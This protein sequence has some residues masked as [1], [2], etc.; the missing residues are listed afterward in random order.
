VVD[1]VSEDIL[2]VDGVVPG[3]SSHAVG[4]LPIG[5]AVATDGREA[6]VASAGEESVT[7]L[8]AETLRTAGLGAPR[9]FALSDTPSAMRLVR[10]DGADR[11]VVA[12]PDEGTIVALDPAGAY[13]ADAGPDA[14]PR[15]GEEV[16]VVPLGAPVGGGDAGP[17]AGGGD[18]GPGD[19]GAD[20][21]GD[22]GPEDAGPLALAQPVD[23]AVEAD[24][25]VW[26]ADI[27]TPFVWHVDLSAATILE[28]I[29]VGETSRRIAV[30]PDAQTVAPDPDTHFLYVVGA[31]SG[32]VTVVD[33]STGERVDPNRSPFDPLATGTGLSVPGLA[34]EALFVTVDD[35]LEEGEEAGPLHLDGTFGLVASSNGGVYVVDVVDRDTRSTEEEP[36]FPTVPY[37]HHL[38]SGVALSDEHA[39]F[40]ARPPVLVRF[41]G[42][43]DTS[44]AVVCL[45]PHFQGVCG[46]SYCSPNP[47]IES[48]DESATGIHLAWEDADPARDTLWRT[49]SEEWDVVF[50]GP[51]PGSTRSRGRVEEEGGDRL[52]DDRADFCA[53]GV[54][55][56]DH[57]VLLA[58]PLPLEE[59]P[60]GCTADCSEFDLV[61]DVGAERAILSVGPQAL[62]VEP[63]GD[64]APCCYGEFTRYQVRIAGEWIVVGSKTGYLHSWKADGDA[65][66]VDPDL[67][68]ESIP[69]RVGRVATGERFENPYL[70]FTM[71]PGEN[72]ELGDSEPLRDDAWVF[73]TDGE[74]APLVFAGGALVAQVARAPV[75]D[76]LFVVDSSSGVTEFSLS[77]LGVTAEFR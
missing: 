3:Y 21:A 60:E 62:E 17:D 38:R 28:A 51:L 70:S 49:T 35:P 48:A 18:A 68:A 55:P 7:V 31:E 36:R 56:G 32:D 34:R 72:P 77:D 45:Q 53:L 50:E 5:V 40:V 46:E 2:D 10:I 42:T 63:W 13:G 19:A 26:V 66:V 57:V 69:L 76:G 23:L 16:A 9:T 65:C 20:D 74:F 22:A 1:L 27:G 14:G 47:D 61:H 24:G 41:D 6:Y 71:V 43:R 52:E 8:P 73:T 54:E 29:D 67:P 37:A 33:L 12:Y 30:T 75:G 15:A 4:A 58:D 11:L 59:Q 64:G 44:C 25:T 39:P